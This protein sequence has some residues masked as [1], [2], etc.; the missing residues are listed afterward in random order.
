MLGPGPLSPHSRSTLVP[1]DVKLMD[2]RVT[3]ST[4]NPD[5]T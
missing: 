4:P 3:P 5:L 2:V 1:P